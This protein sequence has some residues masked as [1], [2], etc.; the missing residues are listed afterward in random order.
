M[1]RIGIN[2]FIIIVTCHAL[3]VSDIEMEILGNFEKPKHVFKPESAK[4]VDSY[5]GDF[6]SS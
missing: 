6:R 3:L 4:T 1:S 5:S 2:G